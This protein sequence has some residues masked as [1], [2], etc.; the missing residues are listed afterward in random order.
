MTGKTNVFETVNLI[1][2]MNT[3]RPP[4]YPRVQENLNFGSSQRLPR[5]ARVHSPSTTGVVDTA[6]AR[7]GPVN[8]L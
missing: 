2:K 3:L 8:S 4:N 7:L 5:A 6:W 1:K